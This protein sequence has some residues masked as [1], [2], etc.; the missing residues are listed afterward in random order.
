MAESREMLFLKLAL[1]NNLVEPAQADQILEHIEERRELGVKK[2]PAEVAVD[3]GFLTE[4]QVQALD[5]ALRST[6]PPEKVG[7]F[8]IG[9]R[10]GRGAVGTVYKGHQVSLDKPVAV[11]IL[12]QNLTKNNIKT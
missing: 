7:G 6:L 1:K 5:S 8:E 2:T 4:A 11:K 12:H 3:K 10:I 9:E